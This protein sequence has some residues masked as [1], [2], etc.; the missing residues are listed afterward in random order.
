MN[1]LLKMGQRQDSLNE[2]TIKGWITKGLNFRRALRLEA[3]EAMDSTPWPWWKVREMDVNNLIVEGVDM[4]HFGLSVAL[5]D[6]YSGWK[7]LDAEVEAVFSKQRNIPEEKLADEIQKVIDNIILMSFD[8]P[9]ASSD[10]SGII[11]DIARYM[12]LLGMS[13]DDMF[14]MY[15]AKNVLNEFRQANGYKE[16]TYLKIWG[17][18]EDNVFMQSNVAEIGISDHFDDDLYKLLSKEYVS[19]V[20]EARNG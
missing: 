9:R 6:G 15:F 7:W 14:K 11:I 3:A 16:G 10:A 1:Y 18:E 4:M 20:D 13:R 17:G 19:V 12:W 5:A 8:I 2:R